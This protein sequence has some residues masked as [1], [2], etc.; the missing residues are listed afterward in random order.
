M[1]MLQ[2]LISFPDIFC[3]ACCTLYTFH[4]D[5]VSCITKL[6]MTKDATTVLQQK[7]DPS[8][9]CFK[10]FWSAYRRGREYMSTFFLNPSN[11]MD[12]IPNLHMR[13]PGHYRSSGASVLGNLQYHN[14]SSSI[15]ISDTLAAGDT[16]PQQNSIELPVSLGSTRG[17]LD[18]V[19]SCTGEHAYGSWKDGKNEMSFMQTVSVAIEDEEDLLH[20]NEPQ[21]SLQREL[22]M[23]DRQSLSL[24]LSD[25]S[26]MPCQGLSLSL[27]TQIPVPSIQYLP[28]SS[29]LSLFC[30]H[31]T[32]SGSGV[33]CRN[34]NYQNMTVHANNC[35]HSHPSVASPVLNFKYL[36]TGQQL[37]NEVV[38]VHKAL[39]QHS[40]K[41]QNLHSSPINSMDKDGTAKSKGEG[42][43]TNPQDSTINSSTELSLSETQD[44]Q[45][46]VTKLLA[47]LDEMILLTEKVCGQ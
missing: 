11:Q 35:Q 15:A 27:T 29:D 18:T 41:A 33:S 37:L 12:K 8:S 17:N 44:L 47:M 42:K 30:P 46:K 6:S 39:K 1:F 32:A 40:D 23:L 24:Q 36:K 31:Q 34:Q 22:G 5:T 28:G 9:C 14:Y 3:T 13:E 10:R 4:E 7:D 25:V 20:G 16:Q 26:T 2:A 19:T 38:N 45:D 43:S 21:I